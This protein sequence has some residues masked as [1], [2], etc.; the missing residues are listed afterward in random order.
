MLAHAREA[1]PNECCGLLV[2]SRGG[3]ARVVRARNLEASPTRYRIDPVDHF[4]AIHEA[5]SQA[6]I[7]VG[8]Y[9]SHPAGAAAPSE[10]DI[11]EATGGSQF[12][13]VIVSLTASVGN[14]LSAFYLVKGSATPVTISPEP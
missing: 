8:A 10:S 12:L 6:Q 1:A 2:G 5:R 4:A 14:E 11:A 3:I 9:H 7:V 13:Y